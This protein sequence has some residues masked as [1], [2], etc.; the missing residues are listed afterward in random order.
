MCMATMASTSHGLSAFANMCVKSPINPKTGSSATLHDR[1]NMLIKYDDVV[2]EYEYE[3]GVPE[4]VEFDN[5]DL[6]NE[7]ATSNFNCEKLLT[8]NGDKFYENLQQLKEENRKTLEAFEK[9]YQDK[10]LVEGLRASNFYEV[11]HDKSGVDREVPADSVGLSIRGVS[12]QT[13]S[14]VDKSVVGKPP[15]GKSRELP[16]HTPVLSKKLPKK[17]AH[18]LQWGRPSSAPIER[19][20]NSLDT[21]QW[22][23]SF[24]QT[25]ES[26]ENFI[27]P[28]EDNSSEY[29]K[30]LAKVDRLWEDF[31]I[32]EH[33]Q[34]RHSFSSSDRKNRDK[35]EDAKLKTSEW[36]HRITIPQPFKMSTREAFK[37]MKKTSAQE[38][39]EKKRLE[40]QQQ[41][42][43]ECEKKFKAQPVPSH[44]YL[45]LYEEIMERN[46]TRRRYIKQYCRELLESQVKPFNFEI[47]E[48]EKKFQR[49]HS[50]PVRR[51]ERVN[52]GFKARPV[53]KHI[54]SP[55]IDEKILEEEELRKIRIKMRSRELIHESSL[56][57]SMA[58]REKLKEQERKEKA[59][60]AKLKIKK[61]RPRNAHDIPNYD[62]LYN[63]FKK[64]LARRRAIREGTVTEPFHL[65]TKH[66]PSNKDKIRKDIIDDEKRLKEN[67]WP[68]LGSRTTP[69]SSI[70]YLGNLSSTHTSL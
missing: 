2:A 70:K 17:S 42:E 50:V 35:S 13:R 28:T 47:R 3:E 63:E 66:I 49:A 8:S 55:E 37:E 6:S 67:R 69:R 62:A 20:S 12:N 10:L 33:I 21:Q 48:Q 15:P 56:P 46:E 38:E 61:S 68:F 41:E 19:R 59:R 18:G 1:K 9:L 4:T 44:V 30:A 29:E 23:E 53:P 27:I 31:K 25:R 34:R 54:F 64:E 22:N 65:M 36:R 58:E 24:F 39:V 43:A 11:E 40:K 32:S 52:K 5:G 51:P 60:L 57:P 16:K 14:R 7:H 45:P 26:G